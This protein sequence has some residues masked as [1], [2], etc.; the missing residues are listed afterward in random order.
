MQKLSE[1]ERA[2]FT[3]I[4]QAIWTSAFG[5]HISERNRT[6]EQLGTLIGKLATEIADFAVMCYR[7]SNKPSE[8]VIESTTIGW[9]WKGQPDLEVLKHALNPLGVEV[10]EDPSCEGS[11]SIGYVFSRRSLT[12]EQLRR[13][14]FTP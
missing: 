5:S 8:D 7:V 13:A 2:Q 10:Y 6:D 9:D 12:P 4:E 11:D 14:S 3:P 1:T